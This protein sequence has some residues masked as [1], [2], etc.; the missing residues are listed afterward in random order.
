MPDPKRTLIERLFAQHQAALYAFFYRRI[1]TKHDAVDLVQEVYV[2]MLRVKDS[3][4]I[5]N[6]EG[7]LYTVAN[8]LV[9][10]HAVLDKRQ[11]AVADSDELSIQGE[12]ARPA[13]FEEMFDTHIH[14][15]RLREV[16][17]QLPPKCRASV[18]MKY[19]LGL[20]YEQIA[21]HLDVSPHMVQKYLVLALAH[22][23]RRMTGGR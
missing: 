3:D 18:Y 14:V 15:K 5:R 16:L 21:L 9:Y 7:Y 17:N 22:C 23:R 11:A 1:R 2:R 20:S 19:H 6:P 10:E 8:N 4:A 12:L 13:G